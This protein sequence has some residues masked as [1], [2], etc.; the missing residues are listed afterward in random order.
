MP[1][2]S[3]L[4]L[5]DF[6]EVSNNALRIA[7]DIA[8]DNGAK[9]TLAHTYETPYITAY[10]YGEVSA[11]I[12]EKLEREM[13]ERLQAKLDEQKKNHYLDGLE[14]EFKLI[15]DRPAYKWFEVLAPKDYDLVTMGTIGHTGLLHGG[16]F[17]TTAQRTIR[18]SPVPVL[19]IPNNYPGTNFSTLLVATDFVE[20]FENELE[21]LVAISKA[22]GAKIVIGVVNSPYAIVP[23]A[24]IDK[25]FAELQAKHPDLQMELHVEDAETVTQGIFKMADHLNADLIAMETTRKKGLM[26][27][28]L[29]SLA[30]DVVGET[31]IPFMCLK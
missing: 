30:E 4:H 23:R 3:I 21:P 8:R 2:S 28:L 5:T 9:I 25:S 26:R 12:E 27:I 17:G 1:I 20:P 10:F 29:G 14:L 18:E 31:A 24:E 11:G 16:L 6:S 7:A 13:L 22:D 15:P 19:A